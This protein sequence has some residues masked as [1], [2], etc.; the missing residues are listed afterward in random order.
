MYSGRY[1]K[2]HTGY[3]A[4]YLVKRRILELVG[5]EQVRGATRHL[6]VLSSDLQWR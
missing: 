4:Q 2:S 6:Y 3:H 1:S 5:T